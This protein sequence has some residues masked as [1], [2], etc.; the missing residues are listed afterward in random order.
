MEP[1]P[2]TVAAEKDRD[3]QTALPKTDAAL[4]GVIVHFHW[5]GPLFL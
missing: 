5:P 3:M 1:K 4:S 2:L